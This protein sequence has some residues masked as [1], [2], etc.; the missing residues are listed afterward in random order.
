MWGKISG[1]AVAVVLLLSGTAVPA[2][3]ASVYKA[4]LRTAARS[5]PVAA[6]V[7]WGYDRTKYFGS[8]KDT[9]RDC[10]NTRHEVLIAE[11]RVSPRLS[12]TRCTVTR[13]KW[14][15]SWDNRTHYDP[16]AVQIDHMVPVH[17]AWG[18][19]ARSWSQARRIAFYNDLGDARSLNAQTSALNSSKQAKGPEDWMPPA[20]RCR[21]IAEWIAVKIRWGLK[22]DSREKAALVRWADSCPAMILTVTRV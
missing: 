8:W 14:V 18:S 2:E 17:E 15:T 19:G 12:S 5:L 21:Y 22:A 16:R 7:N 6:E 9:N 20:N 13:G 11:S 1:A 3:A 4:S 10:Q